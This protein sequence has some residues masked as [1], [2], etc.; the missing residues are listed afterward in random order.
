ML[1]KT[2]H[3]RNIINVVMQKNDDGLFSLTTGVTTV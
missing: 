1:I 3:R 2:M